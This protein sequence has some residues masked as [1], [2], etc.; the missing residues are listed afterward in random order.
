MSVAMLALWKECKP[1]HANL[2]LDYYVM[3]IVSLTYIDSPFQFGFVITAWQLPFCMM[4]I[5][6]LSVSLTY[7][8]II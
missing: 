8:V 1:F 3:V 6:I 4:L 5:D 2:N 7:F